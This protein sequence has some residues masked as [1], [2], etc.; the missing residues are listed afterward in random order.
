MRYTGS[1]LEMIRLKDAITGRPA[2]TYKDTKK[3]SVFH[4]QPFTL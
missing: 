3:L 2:P 4:T 1:P